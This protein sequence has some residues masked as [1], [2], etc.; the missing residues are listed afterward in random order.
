MQ[1][2]KRQVPP[3]FLSFSTIAVRRPNWPALMAAT[4][5]PGPE[6][7]IVTSNASLELNSISASVL[8][9]FNPGWFGLPAILKRPLRLLHLQSHQ[10]FPLWRWDLLVKPRWQVHRSSRATDIEPFD[11]CSQPY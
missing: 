5:P 6:P 9:R 8:V 7:M 3:R 2:L 1:P 10:M 11:Y 4:Y